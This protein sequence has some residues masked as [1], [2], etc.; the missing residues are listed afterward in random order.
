M[1]NHKH[2][3][4]VSRAAYFINKEQ[5]TIEDK[6][7]AVEHITQPKNNTVAAANCGKESWQKKIGDCVNA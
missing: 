5:I 4:T 3:S 1:T 2:K 6:Y 7:E